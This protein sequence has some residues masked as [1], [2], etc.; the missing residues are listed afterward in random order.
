MEG[1]LCTFWDSA[2]NLKYELSRSLK[3]AFD[4][5]PRNGWI[6]NI[7]QRADTTDSDL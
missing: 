3:A 4:Q 6:R 2:D 1:R 5:Y 7:D